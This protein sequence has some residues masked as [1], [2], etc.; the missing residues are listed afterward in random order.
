MNPAYKENLNEDFYR[1]YYKVSLLPRT[2]KMSAAGF[3]SLRSKVI[4]RKISNVDDL[5]TLMNNIVEP[6]IAEDRE[7]QTLQA[8]LHTTWI[9]LLPDS[10]ENIDKRRMDWRKRVAELEMKGIR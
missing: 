9:P 7:Y 3:S 8:L 1:D 5:I 6:D 2:L 10:N 4:E